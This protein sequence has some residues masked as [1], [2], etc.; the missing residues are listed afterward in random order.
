MKKQENRIPV[1]RFSEFKATWEHQRLNELLQ[2]SKEKNKDLKYSKEEVLS[3]SG[4]KGI[5][6]QIDHL[7]RSYAGA[8]VENYGVVNRG[9]IVYTKSPLKSNPYGII[10]LNKGLPG[11]VSTLYAIY[12][13][14]E[15]KADGQFIEHYFS[16]NANTNRY[17]RPLVRKGAKND[18]KINN[19][20][21]L[22]DRIYI[23]K[24]EEQKRIS[25]FLNQ[26]G[27][28]INLLKHKRKLMEE[29]REG[30][31][32]KIFNQELRFNPAKDNTMKEYPDWKEFKV[33]EVLKKYSNPVDVEIG[34]EYNE[35]G[36]RSH[37]KGLFYKKAKSGRDLGNKKVFWL[38]EDLFILNIV[39]AWE[40]AVG[41]TTI[42]EVG[43]IAS[44][45][46]PTFI[47]KESVLSLDYMLAFFKTR[48]GLRLLQLASPG[49]AGRNKTL[50]KKDF[51]NLKV[52]LPCYEEQCQ[53][54]DFFIK[55]NN[56]IELITN[57]INNTNNYRKSLLQQMFT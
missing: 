12:K 48:K 10:K 22:H 55:I 54:S 11:I 7:G 41:K 38:K 57:Q 36:I 21:V 53:I 13:V 28:R 32:Q 40:G 9:D 16:L 42:K 44:H 19:E 8:S 43:K 47:A 6:N 31:V 45:R 18:M 56:K 4:E 5:V 15:D 49:G 39:F 35:I 3:V 23:P 51:N 52:L 34:N 33:S 20:Y 17:L 50:S 14:I 30:I 24:K 46:F 2:V 27:I 1:I 26:I 29:Y 37:G 25:V